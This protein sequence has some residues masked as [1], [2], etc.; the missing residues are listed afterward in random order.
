MKCDDMYQRLVSLL[1]G[2]LDTEENKQVHKHL[3]QCKSCNRVYKELQNTVKVLDHW[4]DIQPSF[5]HIFVRDTSSW[6]ARQKTR[7]EHMGWGTRLA[8]GIPVFAAVALVFLAVLNFRVGYHEGDWSVAFS[9]VPVRTETNRETLFINALEQKQRETLLLV[10]QM[11]EESEY[12]QSNE[13]TLAW[14]SIVQNFEKQRQQDLKM[15]NT[16]MENLQ[17]STEGKFY[18]TSNVLDN[19]IRLTSYNLGSR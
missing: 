4:E 2:E 3:E 9:L 7:I 1:Y 8:C 11:I 18:Q 16:S 6:W 10:S 15:I 17:W 5:K 12:N 13:N 19:L 14:A